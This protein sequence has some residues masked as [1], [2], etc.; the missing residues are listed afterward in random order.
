MLSGINPGEHRGSKY[1]LNGDKVKSGKTEG[2]LHSRKEDTF[3]VPNSG[4]SNN[5]S[6]SSNN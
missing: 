2:A 6:S 4:N 1:D 3:G 5:N